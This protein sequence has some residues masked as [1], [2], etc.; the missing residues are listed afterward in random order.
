[1]RPYNLIKYMTTETRTTTP[2]PTL[3][4][5]LIRLWRHLTK[6]RQRQ[7]GLLLVLMVASALSEVISLG[8]VLPFIGIL[9]APEKVFNNAFVK[10][11]CESFG[12]TSASE[13]VLP[14][15]VI[16]VCAALLAGATRLLMLWVSTRLSN[17][18]GADLSIEIYKRTL[19]QPYKVHVAR[20]SSEVINGIANKSWVTVSVLQSLLS[21]VSSI[22]LSGTLVL[23]LIAIDPLVILVATIVF[24]CCYGAV[25]WA[26]RRR[27]QVNSQRIA[28]EST[29]VIKALQE[30]LGGIRDVLLN[31]S[32]P[33]YCDIYQ[34]ADVPYRRANAS[35]AFIAVSP[36][37]AMEAIGMVLIGIL[38]YAISLQTGG[39]SSA[40]PVLGALALGAQRILPMLQIAYS[41]WASIAGSQNS[42]SDTLDLLD[43]PLPF[44]ISLP[45]PEPLDFKNSISFESVRFRYL[46]DGPWVL[47]GVS[48]N[49]PK[50]SRVGFVGVT[51]SGKTT[52]LDLLMGLLDPDEGQILVDN[53]PT[54][55]DRRRAWQRAIAHVPQSIFLADI[56]IAENIAFGIPRKS[57]D[58]DRVREA[59]RQAQIDKFIESR[60]NGYNEFVGER[61]IRLS[62]GQRQ[63][64]GI[65]RALY[66]EASVLVFDEATS[67]LDNATEQAVMESIE[68]L[69]RNLT[70]LIIAHRLTTV[71][72][73]DEIIE[74]EHGK[75]VAQGS[76]QQLLEQ[77][78]SFKSMALAVA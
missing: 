19:Y 20:N 54:T 6:R 50:G 8:A 49:I 11:I 65:A 44:D 70:I 12:I 26:A 47:D 15:T 3:R 71:Q 41:S 39:V 18:I 1:M 4:S 17:A 25:T 35:N 69:N 59:A 9:T 24:G 27:L 7:L 38:A 37:F 68:D 28:N 13:L 23:T 29:Q 14:L 67:S 22:L 36:R 51:G 76:Y 42:L 56:T 63:R 53:L 78:Q 40:L 57:I 21:A 31:G 52:L 16:F 32:Q 77:S 60:R 5:L 55:G 74:L 62:G 48:F 75:V 43:Q 66:K 73:C 2:Q 46:S 30:G 64:I 45:E 10:S 72:R 34:R 33:V 58:M 61:G